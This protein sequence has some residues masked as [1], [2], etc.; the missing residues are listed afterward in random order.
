[1]TP[2]YRAFETD[3]IEEF[4]SLAL[5]P[6]W[7]GVASRILESGVTLAASGGP[8]CPGWTPVPLTLRGE[9]ED[10]Q[11][12]VTRS[13]MYR[14]H[15]CLHNLWPQ[16]HPQRTEAGRIA[17]KR[18]QMA[19]EVAVLTLTEF[20]YG[21]W[22]F[23]TYPQLRP[24]V[25]PRVAVGLRKGL[26]RHLS[27]EQIAH[28]IADILHMGK[29][30]AWARDNPEVQSWLD[31]YGPMLAADRALVDRCWAAI[32]AH[33][34]QPP[35]DAPSA[36]TGMELTGRETTAWMVQDFDHLVRSHAAPDWGLVR[37]NRARRADIQLPG[38]WG[39]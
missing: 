11:T 34:W 38:Q 7:K 33:D 2:L 23:D 17:Y 12:R 35:A 29:E 15:D 26:F 13:V 32:H 20:G 22:L 25:A 28:R 36:R 31:Y 9:G 30:Y 18:I 1:M 4:L 6:A 24:V 21:E 16:P 19:G 3:D 10:L 37:L 27:L 14:V 8:W 5:P 39:S